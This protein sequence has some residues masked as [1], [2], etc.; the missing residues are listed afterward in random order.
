[1]IDTHVHFNLKQFVNI[2]EEI[3]MA[4]INGVNQFIVIGFDLISSIKA[5]QL[6]EKYDC[7]YAVI[8]CHTSV[9]GYRDHG[10]AGR[11]YRAAKSNHT[12]RYGARFHHLPRWSDGTFTSYCSGREGLGQRLPQPCAL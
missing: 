4:N 9:S 5:I 12:Y 6:S 3:K 1:M 11:A 2:D 7:I 8:G 10:W